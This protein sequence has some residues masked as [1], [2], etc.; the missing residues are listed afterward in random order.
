MPAQKCT[1]QQIAVRER[2]TSTK[3]EPK[4]TAITQKPGQ[5]RCVS[6]TE[7]KF[8][9]KNK[10]RC[11]PRAFG[12]DNRTGKNSENRLYHENAVKNSDNTILK[13][14]ARNLTHKTSLVPQIIK[15]TQTS[16]RRKGRL[17]CVF[18]WTVA[19]P[20]SWE[21]GSSLLFRAFLK[22]TSSFSF[23]EDLTS[24]A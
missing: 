19:M 7:R 6:A 22:A 2:Q 18:A 9:A 12:Y 23:K 1:N 4:I 16:S 15:A 10:N 8:H 5:E 3:N 20:Y 17:F 14:S 24:W 21:R 11:K 13:I